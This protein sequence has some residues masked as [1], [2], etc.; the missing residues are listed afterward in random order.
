MFKSAAVALAALT[1]SVAPAAADLSERFGKASKMR[2]SAPTAMPPSGYQGQW[3]TSPN[4]CEYSRSG[5]PGEVVW[6]LI[7]NKA[8]RNCQ[9]YIV[10]RGFKDA[11]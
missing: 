3:W 9:P 11:Y 1:L 7:I 2:A 6:Y 8:H 5:R 10:Q 4:N